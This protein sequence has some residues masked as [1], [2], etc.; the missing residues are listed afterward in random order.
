MGFRVRNC[1]SS[2]QHG[3]DPYEHVICNGND[4][5]YDGLDFL[6][7]RTMS[8]SGSKRF[9]DWDLERKNKV[10]GGVALGSCCVHGSSSS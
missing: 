7:A 5:L 1:I 4:A 10:V 3:A 2:P 9:P 8:S 6:D